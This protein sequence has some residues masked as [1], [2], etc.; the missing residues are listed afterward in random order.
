V[1][2][3]N[4][5]TD[6]LPNNGYTRYN[7][8]KSFVKCDSIQFKCFSLFTEVSK[9]YKLEITDVIVLFISTIVTI[10]NED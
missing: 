8:N 10:K 7:I 9:E 5:F 6:P 4:V 2:C 1:L 3:G